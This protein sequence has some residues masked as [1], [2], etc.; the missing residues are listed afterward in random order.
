MT[1]IGTPQELVVRVDRVVGLVVSRAATVRLGH[2]DF[3]DQVFDAPIVMHKP[4]GQV[5]QQFLIARFHAVEA[6]IARRFY[7][8]LADQM[9]P[10]AVCH[11]ASGQRVVF[12]SH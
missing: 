6:K 4:N 10:N 9:H 2:H 11:D 3:T 1:R 5:I 7:Q 8:R 12:G